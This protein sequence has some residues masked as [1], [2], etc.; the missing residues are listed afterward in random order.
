MLLKEIELKSLSRYRSELM[1]VAIIF[2]MLFHQPLERESIFFGLYRMGNIGVEMFLFLSGIGLWFSWMKNPSMKYFYRK[3]LLRIYPTWIIIASVY[4]LMN[5]DWQGAA[6]KD[7]IRLFC[8]IA[9]YWSYWRSHSLTFWFIATIV[10]FYFLAP[11][12]MRLIQRY[13]IYRWLPV[14]LIVFCVFMQYF[15][16]VNLRFWDLEITW[17]RL[18]IFFIGINFGE[19]VRS[20]KRIEPAGRWLFLISFVFSSVLCI[21]LEQMIHGEFPMFIERLVYIPMSIS[22]M[23]LLTD[24]YKRMPAWSLKTLAFIGAIT[25]ELYLVHEHFILEW[26]I[27]MNLGY[28]TTAGLTI[29]LSIPLAWILKQ[30]TK[31]IPM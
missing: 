17:S 29:A 7:Y 13:P 21:Y 31:R 25:L 28:W 15:R 8:D 11:F 2:I 20:E 23:L 22:L 16:P 4:F 14:L 3:R 26:L 19:L 9:F 18:P 24:L 30:V 5:F 12:Y 1:G 27:P 10:L 6:M